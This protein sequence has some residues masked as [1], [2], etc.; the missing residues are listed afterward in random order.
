MSDTAVLYAAPFDYTNNRP[1]MDKEFRD[2]PGK[3]PKKEIPPIK[4]IEQ[5][6]YLGSL[7]VA[8]DLID[9]LDKKVDRLGELVEHLIVA[10][11]TEKELKDLLKKVVNEKKKKNKKTKPAL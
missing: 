4:P 8:L 1:W 5:K 11:A 9:K 2:P 7:Q 3:F 6:V 10:L